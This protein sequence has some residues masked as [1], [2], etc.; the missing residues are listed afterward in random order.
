MKNSFYLDECVCCGS[1]NLNQILD[2]GH[3]PPA[4]NYL[5]NRLDEVD[6][7]PLGINICSDCWH[8]QLTYCVDRSSI[9]DNYNYVSGTSQTLRDYFNW[10]A[11]SLRKNLKSDSS[12]LEIAANDGSL[13]KKLIEKGLDAIGID[14]AKNIVEKANQEGIPIICGYWPQA[15][16]KLTKKYDSIICMNV[17]A[18]V[19]DPLSFLE[20]CKNLITEEGFIIIQPSQARMF[21]NH[22]FDTCYHEHI[23]F[24]NTRSVSKLAERAGLDLKTALMTKIHGDSPLYILANKNSNRDF[25]FLKSTFSD[26]PFSI[27][28]DLFSYEK[29]IK[30]YNLET[31]RQ[32]QKKTYEILDYLEKTIEEHREQGYKIAFVGAAA[33]GM[34]VINSR[35]LTPDYFFDESPFKINL[36]APGV[37]TIITS[38]V[39]C[40]EIREKTL[41]IITAWNFKKELTKKITDIHKNKDSK[42]FSYFP[43]PELL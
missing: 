42:F 35:N 16:K 6:L 23:S 12:V 8:A 13:I 39:E 27:K 24:F 14:P 30:L 28:E 3:Q 38:L 5:V 15:S 36:Y 9:F 7:Y 17:L 29:N 41:F 32:F 25:N 34:T 31:Y 1:S 26:G 37:K 4:N 40:K 18:H 20:A 2:L 19:S 21:E 10:F 43:K 11:D 22:E 33:K